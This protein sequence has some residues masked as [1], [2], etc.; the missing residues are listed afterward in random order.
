M[1][2]LTAIAMKFSLK[3][4]DS[5]QSP[6]ALTLLSVYLIAEKNELT[7]GSRFGELALLLACQPAGSNLLGC[8]L[9]VHSQGLHLYETL[10]AGPPGSV[11]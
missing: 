1:H 7:E 2:N 10:A 9:V 3:D 6:E 11:H 8:A 4:G 5:I